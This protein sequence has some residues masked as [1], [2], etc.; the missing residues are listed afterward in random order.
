MQNLFNQ[1]DKENLIERL[2]KLTPNHLPKWGKM[3]VHQAVVHM[4]D[5]LRCALGIRPVSVHSGVLSVWP[6]NKLI[7]QYLPWIKGAPTAPEFTQGVKGSQLIEFEKDKEE[8]ILTIHRFSQ[9]QNTKP[10][11]FHPVFGKLKNTEWARVMWR[12]INH[13]LTQFGL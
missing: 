5:P 8:L 13:H 12:H 10:F 3:N 2:S 4:T 6:I 11:P 9:E 7:S 1:Q